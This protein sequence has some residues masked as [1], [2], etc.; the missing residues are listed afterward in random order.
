[1]PL[2]VYPE[3][4]CLGRRSGRSIGVLYRCFP[5]LRYSCSIYGTGRKRRK[6]TWSLLAAQVV[7]ATDPAQTEP[8]V[9]GRLQPQEPIALLLDTTGPQIME[10]VK[11]PAR[12]LFTAFLERLRNAFSLGSETVLLA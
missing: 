8:G 3:S 4:G 1:M 10:W 2:L 6:E 9:W 7:F 5:E 12:S 11:E